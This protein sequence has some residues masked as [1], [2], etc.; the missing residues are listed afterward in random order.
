MTIQDLGSIGEFVAA[1]ATV[2]TLAYLALQIH[3]SNTTAR[4]QA[5]QT[6]IDT[7][8]SRNWELARDPRM[9]HAFAE[10]LSRWPDLSNE[11][12]TIFDTGMGAYIANIQNGLLL[13][14]SGLLD[15]AVY[16]QIASNMIICV[17][18]V[19]GARWW[20]DTSSPSPEL[21]LY[22]AQR[23]S[24]NDENLVPIDEAMPWWMALADE[25]H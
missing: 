13:R 21:R 5:R 8:A 7:W 15:A 9:L 1:I 4:A 11:S 19:G 3:Q 22:V 24:E 12:K 10:G 17:K 18:S 23:L 16:D 25:K 20:K 14:E 6:L 2:G